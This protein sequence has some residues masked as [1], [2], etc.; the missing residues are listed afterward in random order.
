MSQP[1]W[2]QSLRKKVY[3]DRNPEHGA[4][5]AAALR[6]AVGHIKT[7]LEI[8]PGYAEAMAALVSVYERR[9]LFERSRELASLRVLGFTRAEISF[10]LL[11]ELA[12]VTVAALPLG[13]VP[14]V[15]R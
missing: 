6:E 13:F 4:S 7:A 10:I 15:H 5:R 9:G 14:D 3:A 1:P 8:N 11:G 12:V 2:P